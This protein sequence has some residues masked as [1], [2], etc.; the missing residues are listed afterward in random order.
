V[1]GVTIPIEDDDALNTVTKLIRETTHSTG[2]WAA[3]A[4]E[5]PP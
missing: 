1:N 3:Y 2:T 5:F 4:A